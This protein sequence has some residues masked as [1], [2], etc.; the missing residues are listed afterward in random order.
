VAAFNYTQPTDATG[1]QDSYAFKCYGIGA[2]VPGQALG[3]ATDAG[4]VNTKLTL[5]LGPI[6][7][8]TRY[9]P[10]GSTAFLYIQT[11]RVL[12]TSGALTT[13]A[14]Y[15][16]VGTSPPTVTAVTFTTGK[17]YIRLTLSATIDTTNAYTLTV[18]ANTF[19]D[20]NGVTYNVSRNIPI[21]IDNT[22]VGSG[23]AETINVGSPAMSH[24]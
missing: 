3:H 9:S 17:S 8:V 13:A 24:T 12:I 20:V 11:D 14:N 18:A 10:S 15:T 23:I 7:W 16:L 21:V 22:G 4:T 5:G 2:D 1:E 19:S 6:P